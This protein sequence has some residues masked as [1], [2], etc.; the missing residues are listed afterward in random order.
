MGPRREGPGS[1]GSREGHVEGRGSPLRPPQPCRTTP[2][3]PRSYWGP[4][5]T[6]PKEACQGPTAGGT[7]PWGPRGRRAFGL[8]GRRGSAVW[9]GPGCEGKAL[10]ASGTLCARAAVGALGEGVGEEWAPRP[11]GQLCPPCSL[12][13]GTG[14]SGVGPTRSLAPGLQGPPTCMGPLETRELQSLTS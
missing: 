9:A 6:E 7:R 13:P 1:A 10:R 11:P 14:D 8:P 4:D 2:L 5:G 3:C 12:S